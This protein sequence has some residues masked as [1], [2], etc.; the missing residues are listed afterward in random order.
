MCRILLLVPGHGLDRGHS[1]H[2]RFGAERVSNSG[3]TPRRS[4]PANTGARL[5][6]LRRPPRIYALR[7]HDM[8]RRR[9]V[10]SQR[11]EQAATS[12]RARPFR[13][14]RLRLNSLGPPPSASSW[15]ERH[16]PLLD[17]KPTVSR[18]APRPDAAIAHR[19]SL[20]DVLKPQHS[21]N[22]R[23]RRQQLRRALPPPP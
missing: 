2:S 14:G 9:H 23:Q 3:G 19:L 4:R 13:V 20:N 18:T 6:C 15:R 10:D 22:E 7:L 1:E 16:Q 11:R 5:Q 21:S 12:R 8:R 17:L